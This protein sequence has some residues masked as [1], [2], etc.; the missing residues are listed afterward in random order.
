MFRE[1]IYQDIIKD[2]EPLT[3]E[4]E[5]DETMF[6]WQKTG[7]ARLGSIRKEYGL[8]YLLEKG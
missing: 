1:S 2:L 8:W 7:Q 6:G 4:I 5:M 3:G